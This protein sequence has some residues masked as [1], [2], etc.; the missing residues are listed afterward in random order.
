MLELN[1]VPIIGKLRGG[2]NQE[3]SNHEKDRKRRPA[4]VL[5]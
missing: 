5:E 2:E 3:K 4:L 1:E